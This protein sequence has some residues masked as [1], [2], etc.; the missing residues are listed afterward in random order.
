VNC[1]LKRV[2]REEAKAGLDRRFGQT[3]FLLVSE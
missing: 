1:F 2:Q 3:S